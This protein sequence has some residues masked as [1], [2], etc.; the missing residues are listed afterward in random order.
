MVVVSSISAFQIISP[1][2]NILTNLNNKKID[3]NYK[4]DKNDKI[5]KT[6]FSYDSRGE[7][8]NQAMK[9]L[10]RNEDVQNK[11][12]DELE[13]ILTRFGWKWAVLVSTTGELYK[14]GESIPND[15]VKDLRMTR[16]LIESGCYS[17]CDIASDLRKVEINL[18]SMLMEYGPHKT[19]KFLDLLGK[20]ISGKLTEDELDITAAAPILPDCITLPCVCLE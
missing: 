17:T 1:F 19:D 18:F 9:I 20:A 11:A 14:K 8:N 7:M 16:T 15:L 13:E 10:S 12:R 4:N 2:G 6:Y 5:Y 3:N